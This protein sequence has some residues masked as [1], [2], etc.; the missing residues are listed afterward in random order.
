MRMRRRTD[1]RGRPSQSASGE[2]AFGVGWV[3]PWPLPRRRQSGRGLRSTGAW[4][5]LGRRPRCRASLRCPG[6]CLRCLSVAQSSLCPLVLAECASS[7][8]LPAAADGAGRA[9]LFS[10]GPRIVLGLYFP[11][12]YIDCVTP[13]SL[14][15]FFF[16]LCC[17]KLRSS[18]FVFVLFGKS[19]LPCWCSYENWRA[20]SGVWLAVRP[21]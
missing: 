8:S 7:H 9:L 19:S 3:P 17:S 13:S 2:T 21:A 14:F 1:T 18:L 20:W 16:P 5:A 12:N 15:I 11:L 6:S 10:L 4:G